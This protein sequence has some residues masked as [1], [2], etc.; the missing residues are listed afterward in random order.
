M[1]HYLMGKTWGRA[2][3]DYIQWKD[4]KDMQEMEKQ[5]KKDIA[6]LKENDVLDRRIEHALERLEQDITFLAN[7]PEQAKYNARI[8]H[9]L[10][11]IAS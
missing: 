7:D 2:K 4:M 9:A 8:A 11:E 10:K 5:A 3:A 6:R 1:N